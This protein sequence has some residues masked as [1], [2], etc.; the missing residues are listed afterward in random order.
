[1]TAEVDYA[2]LTRNGWLGRALPDLLQ[3]NPSGPL[4]GLTYLAKDLFD[5]K[6][7]PT[8][9]GSTH[10]LSAPPAKAD[11]AIIGSLTKAGAL[12]VG[13][14]NMDPLAYGFVTRNPIYGIAKNPHDRERICGGSS[15]GSAG[16]VASGLVDFALGTDTS[17]SIRIPAAFCGI[18]GIKP[19][20]GFLSAE[21]VL[22]LSPTLDRVGLLARD[23]AT[24]QKIFEALAPPDNCTGALTRMAVLDGYFAD[25]LTSDIATAL[26]Q[27]CN[28]IGCSRRIS[29]DGAKA[30]RGA[31][32]I[33]VAAEAAKVHRAALRSAP[34]TFDQETRTRLAA[35]QLIP[36]EW[37][38]KAML[39]A[40]KF[41]QAML[42]AL[43]DADV[44][45]APTVPC[46]APLITELDSAPSPNRQPL[47]ASLGLYTQ[48]ISL[49][50]FPVVSMPVQTQS[51]MP[52]ALQL[53]GR[54]GSDHQLLRLARALG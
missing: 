14:S 54:P 8:I 30:A 6:G 34:K 17:G 31:A 3:A 1:M 49:S 33:I 26:D 15:G 2:A 5:I 39:E 53:I 18:Y 22:P 11:A 48:P 43:D 28:Q 51:G 25:G 35:A 45:I 10:R 41:R 19:T 37:V 36:N 16:A 38:E 40:G 50:G 4:A 20:S 32:Y 24:L 21:G 46:V 44:L 29:V 27:T 52:T 7:E 12:L 23:A 47:R 13:T 42:S 9:A